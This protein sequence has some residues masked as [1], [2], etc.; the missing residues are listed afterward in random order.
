[1]TFFHR[2]RWLAPWGLLTPGMAWLVIFFVVPLG[3]L[4]YQS[5]QSGIFPSYEFT[6]EFSNYR[7][8][9][10]DNREQLVRSFWYAGIATVL[11]LAFSYPLAYW[12][13]FRAGK[14]KNVFLV[15]VVAPFFVTYL[16]RTIAWQ[17]IL[18]DDGTVVSVLRTVGL[19]ADDGRLLATSTAVV[20]GITYNYLPFA[21]LP[22]YVSLEQVDRRL[23]E[24]AEDLYASPTAGVPAGDA[25]A[26]APRRLRGDR[27]DV[28][29][30]RRR[31][32]QR[33][34]PGRTEPGHDRERDPVEVPRPD[35]LSVGGGALL[36]ADGDHRRH[37]RDLRPDRR[38]G[39]A[40]MKGVRGRV[41]DVYAILA[42]GYM[43]LPI[44]VVFLF[45]FNDPA[46]RFN[47]VWQSFTFDNWVNWDAVP[48]LRDALETSLL[49]AVLA[50][51]T[52]TALG[53]LIALALVRHQFRGRGSIN[54][55]IFLPMAAPEIVLGASLL[56]LFL[57]QSLLDLG[58]WTIF[59]AHVM[60]CISFVVVT[61]RARLV[62]F[63]RHLEEAAADLGATGL[64][65]FRLVT[66]PLL[67]PAILAGGLLAFAI[68]VDDFV[69][70]YFNSGSEIT[71]PVFVWGQAARGVPPQV[72]V[73]GSAIFLIAVGIMLVSVIVQT[74]RRKESAA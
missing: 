61:V 21:I 48:G 57:N 31:L 62:D 8:A 36:R 40:R 32:H 15:L 69:I 22:I 20:A 13:A 49:I 68:S 10:S 27:A 73:I 55:L 33:G 74:R 1:M 24:A 6:W 17:T 2:H 70:T 45:S 38:L 14:W 25:A 3:F 65:T 64:E 34:A 59:I 60:F 52:A 28:H 16:I 53:T 67:W 11:A 72:N 30:L 19:L 44:A 23:V 5:L 35:R 66:L 29:P 18:S 54:F 26:L 42:I 7:E 37:D 51:L 63:D 12:I 56:T 50:S 4:A 43:L 46:G 58:F 9:L 71:F 47:Y 39:A 41:L